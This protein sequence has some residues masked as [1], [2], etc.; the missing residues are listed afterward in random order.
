MKNKNYLMLFQAHEYEPEVQ[1]AAANLILALSA[2]GINEC[3]LNL[4][5]VNFTFNSLNLLFLTC[6][7]REIK[8]IFIFNTEILDL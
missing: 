8:I 3:L 6:H 4:K 7:Y 2:D 5:C 1:L